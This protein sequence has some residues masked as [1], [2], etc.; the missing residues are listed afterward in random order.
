MAANAGNAITYTYGTNLSKSVDYY[1]NRAD[2]GYS[3]YVHYD[4]SFDGSAFTITSKINLTGDDAGALVSTWEKGI[5]TLWS[6]KFCLSDGASAYAIKVDVQFTDVNAD[7]DVAVHNSYGACDLLNWYTDTAWGPDYQDE[8]AAHEFGHM[9]GMFDEY[10]GG[11]TWNGQTANG[12]IMSDLGSALSANYF[13]SVD[14]NAESLL[15][16]S[17][18]VVAYQPPA[19]VDPAGLTLYG[20]A[21]ADSLNGAGGA[22][23]LE[24]KGGDDVLW[25]WA[26]NDQLWGVAGNDTLYGGSGNDGLYGGSGNDRLYGDAGNDYLM[27]SPGSDTLTGGSGADS[28]VMRR[29]DGHDVI[30]DFNGW[31]GDR[32]Q[33]SGGMGW[34]FAGA[35]DGV[36]VNF[37]SGDTMVLSGL[38][39]DHMVSDWVFAV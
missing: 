32:I 23:Y 4:L 8:L 1:E 34:S 14:T 13:F 22:D 25:G 11:A 16:R 37:T 9:I 5:E 36:H 26:G 39:I 7:Y 33:V 29:G 10:A 6:N 31:Q 19:P 3:W 17:L 12:T 24:G 2:G 28:F 27:G 18:E 20:T 15:G 30:T 21:K 35:A 38:T